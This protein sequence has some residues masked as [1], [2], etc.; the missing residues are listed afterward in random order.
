MY[1]YLYSCSLTNKGP[2]QGTHI[3]LHAFKI[4][5]CL[6]PTKFLIIPCQW[7]IASFLDLF[8]DLKLKWISHQNM[9]I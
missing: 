3:P 5:T 2:L 8:I 7:K 6:I 9:Q 1:M 4:S